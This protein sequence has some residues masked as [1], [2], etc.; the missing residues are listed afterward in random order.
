MSTK[1]KMFRDSAFSQE[2]SIQTFKKEYQELTQKEEKKLKSKL[3]KLFEM[4]FDIKSIKSAL[5]KKYNSKF[6]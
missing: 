3:L 1:K 5:L 2:K 4:G 6:N